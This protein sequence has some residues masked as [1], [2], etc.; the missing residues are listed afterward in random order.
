MK[1]LAVLLLGGNTFG[2]EGQSILEHL[3]DDDDSICTVNEKA[4]AKRREKKSTSRKSSST[5]STKE[6]GIASKFAG[7]SGLMGHGNP[8]QQRK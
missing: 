6:K 7:F 4:L 3:Q 8:N 5:S 1:S 2:E